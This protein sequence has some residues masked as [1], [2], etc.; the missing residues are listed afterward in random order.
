MR[1]GEWPGFHGLRIALLWV[2]LVA[3]VAGWRLYWRVMQS[4]ADGAPAAAFSPTGP[5][6]VALGPPLVLAAA[7]ALLRRRRGKS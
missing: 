3:A 5:I 2:I 4:A 6:L 1:L 7:Y